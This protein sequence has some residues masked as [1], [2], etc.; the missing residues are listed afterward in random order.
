MCCTF[1][2]TATWASWSQKRKHLPFPARLPLRS[3]ARRGRESGP[4]SDAKKRPGKPAAGKT[5]H[6]VQAAFAGSGSPPSFMAQKAPSASAAAENRPIQRLK[7][8]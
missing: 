4:F 7:P 3:R 5:E 1:G 8:S 2:R 6:P